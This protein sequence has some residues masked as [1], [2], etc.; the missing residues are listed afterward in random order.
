MHVKILSPTFNLKSQQCDLCSLRLSCFSPGCKK[1][2]T[3]APEAVLRAMGG[4]LTDITGQPYKYNKDVVHMD[5]MGVL[6]T[7]NQQIHD[8]IVKDMPT[9]AVNSLKAKAKK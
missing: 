8:D 3:C 6:A 1:W 7:P 9:E 5:A 2:D 4:V